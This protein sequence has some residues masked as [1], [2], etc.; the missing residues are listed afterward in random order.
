MLG[1]TF[2]YAFL[3]FIAF[4]TLLLGVSSLIMGSIYKDR[5]LIFFGLKAILIA[6]VVIAII[7]VLLWPYIIELMPGFKKVAEFLT[8]IF[9]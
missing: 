1:W 9:K 6:I 8:S 3:T 5:S 7:G 2:L 4:I